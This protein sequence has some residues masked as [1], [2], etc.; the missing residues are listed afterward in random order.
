MDRF[1][2]LFITIG[3]AAKANHAAHH[4]MKVNLMIAEIAH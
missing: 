2:S 3:I 4:S 1:T